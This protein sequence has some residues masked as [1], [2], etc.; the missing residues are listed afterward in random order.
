MAKPEAPASLIPECQ[1]PR[2]GGP[3]NF[4]P[5][6]DY[7][8]HWDPVKIGPAHDPIS[9]WAGAWSCATCHFS[10]TE[11]ELLDDRNMALLFGG[12]RLSCEV[13]GERSLLFTRKG[14]TLWTCAKQEH[15]GCTPVPLETC[16]QVE[17]E[18]VFLP[19]VIEDL[20]SPSNS[21]TRPN[22]KRELGDVAGAISHQPSRG[23]SGSGG[24]GGSGAVD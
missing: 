21:N 1:C 3:P 19:I 2:I 23:A 4:A 15:G 14:T 9:P 24:P 16:P 17:V 10:I 22:R 12:N 18:M 20:E 5:I 11:N 6:D 7:R 8:M 13:H